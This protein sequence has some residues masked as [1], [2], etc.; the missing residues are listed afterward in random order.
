MWNETYAL[1]ELPD[2][3]ETEE[4][5]D[6]IDSI[7]DLKEGST[8]LDLCCG[9]GRHALKLSETGYYVI[10][11]DFS[12]VLLDIANDLSL[13][14]LWF[15]EGDMRNIPLQKN[16]CDAVVN[17]FTSFG[18]FDD[19]DN[20]QVLKSVS[21]VLKRKGKFLLDYWNPYSAVQLDGTRN[22]WWVSDKVLSLAEVKYDYASGRLQDHRTIIDFE[23]ASMVKSI[24]DM[25]F[26]T[27][28]ELESMLNSAGLRIIG[29]YGDIDERDYD[30]NSRRLITLSEKIK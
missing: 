11:L 30:S 23:K 16:S 4:E 18:F 24:R 13:S 20:L 29:V 2:D 10:G 21:S 14:N 6:F 27:L 25:K 7:L 9:Q 3:D 5:V 19:K 28:P 26:Y 22:W 17:M 1:S 12:S 15:I 8:I